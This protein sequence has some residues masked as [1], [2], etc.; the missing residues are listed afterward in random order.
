M[1]MQLDEIIL[2]PENIPVLRRQI[3]GSG[4]IARQDACR[5][6][7]PLRQPLNATRPRECFASSS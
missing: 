5:M 3:A 1:I 4:R 7:S 2:R 6:T